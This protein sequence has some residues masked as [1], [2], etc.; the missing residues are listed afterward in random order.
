M[1]K[2]KDRL[3]SAAKNFSQSAK[4]AGKAAAKGARATGSVAAQGTKSAGDAAAESAKAAGE[5]VRQG[6]RVTGN[7]A[8][9]ATE[10]ARSAAGQ[11]IS[12]VGEGAGVIGQRVSWESV[13]PDPA[14][15]TLAASIESSVE[16]SASAKRSL[17]AQ[18]GPTLDRLPA[19]GMS[20]QVQTLSAIQALLASEQI[21]RATNAWLQDLVSGRATI[22][23]K[24]MDSVFHETSIGGGYHRLFDGGHTLWGAF[25]AIR[26]ASPDDNIFQ[27]AAGLL[28][29]LARDA[30]TPRGLP[31]VTWNE[32]SF[33]NLANNLDNFGISRAW[34]ND[35]ASYD[36]VELVA[37]S[38]GIL[39]V[40]L[41]WNNDDVEEFSSIVGTIGLSAVVS[42]NPLMLMVTVA[43]LAKAFHS[44]RKT[45]DWKEFSDG[46]AKGGIC[47]GAVLLTTSLV[48][49]PTVVVLL[50]GICVG[51]LA[52]QATKRV[53]FVEIGQFMVSEIRKAP[54][55]MERVVTSTKDVLPTST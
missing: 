20:A 9:R 5:R 55:A 30:T 26:D 6:M 50:T 10:S 27:E 21:S 40:A 7:A 52:H 54:V 29:A 51:I 34:L 14:R 15:R 31:L 2:H 24:A 32:E 37:G 39:A 23:D 12:T 53:S 42:A 18:I 44:A 25:H 43:A 8:T 13:L 36:V 22:Y 28:Q 45:G 49:G 47:T 16:L 4:S 41:N 17:I 35:L 1:P 38:I 46:I 33:N 11:G 3:K 19:N 48:S